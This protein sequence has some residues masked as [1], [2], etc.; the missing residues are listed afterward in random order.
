MPVKAILEEVAQTAGN[1]GG[2]IRF[3]FS[4]AFT[5]PYTQMDMEA[6][7]ARAVNSWAEEKLAAFAGKGEGCDTNAAR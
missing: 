4:L 1:S 5:L 7:M 3:D 6:A 2:C